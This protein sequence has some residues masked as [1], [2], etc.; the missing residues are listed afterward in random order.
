MKRTLTRV[1]SLFLAVLC[2]A[3]VLS[4]AASAAAYYENDLPVVY[5]IGRGTWI[6]DKNE[7]KI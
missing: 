4:P 3:A 2:A 7:N 6:Y 1:L 5:V